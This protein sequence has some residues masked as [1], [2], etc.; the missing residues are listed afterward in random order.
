M[1]ENLSA[2]LAPILMA[3]APFITEALVAL[4]VLIGA[5][6]G[7]TVRKY[8]GVQAEKI[9]RDALHQAI[10]TGLKQGRLDAG[11]QQIATE[12]AVEYARRSVPDAIAG[13]GATQNILLNIAQSKF[14]DL[15]KRGF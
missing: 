8:L 10:E 1:F 11:L 15:R 12:K 5:R 3:L 9:M 13:L 6:V 4:F 14:E 2:A 7:Q